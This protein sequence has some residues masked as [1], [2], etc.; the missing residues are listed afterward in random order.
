[1]KT[2]KLKILGAAMLLLTAALHAQTTNKPILQISK[3]GAN[4]RAVLSWNSRTNEVYSILY[5]TNLATGFMSA[6][7]DF[8][9]QGTNSVWSDIG[10]ESGLGSRSSSADYD[11]P[12][13]FYR[14]SVQG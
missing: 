11:A 1:M 12:I 7:T 5:S 8:A 4:A 3:N 6:A 13:R 2:L 9:N 14:L 10:T